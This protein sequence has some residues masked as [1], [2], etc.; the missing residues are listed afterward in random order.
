MLEYKDLKLLYLLMASKH[1]YSD[2]DLG[3]II[4]DNLNWN[5]HHDAILGKAYRTL[6]IV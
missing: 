4:S 5:I 1:P 3:V 2:R 6:G